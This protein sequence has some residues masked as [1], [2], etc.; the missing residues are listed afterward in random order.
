MFPPD[1]DYAWNR[2]PKLYET[3]PR[4]AR[5]L[6][7]EY[8]HNESREVVWAYGKELDFGSSQ[9]DLSIHGTYST[10]NDYKSWIYG[11]DTA[12]SF[13]KRESVGFSTARAGTS[14]WTIA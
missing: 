2:L 13:A 8:L 7:M 14:F 6:Q 4:R 1:E 3:A 12:L 5:R 9:L 11:L 10:E